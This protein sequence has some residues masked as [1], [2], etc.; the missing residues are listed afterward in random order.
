MPYYEFVWTERARTKIELHGATCHDVEEVISRPLKRG[1]SNSSGRP[2]AMGFVDDGR[3]LV[4]IYE[5][6]DE[7]RILP[8]T[9]YFADGQP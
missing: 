4:C 5:E 2:M 7:L 9:A 1:R 6:L 3:W 8:V